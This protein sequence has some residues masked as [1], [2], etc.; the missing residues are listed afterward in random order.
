MTGNGPEPP[1][2]PGHPAH[3]SGLEW[4]WVLAAQETKLSEALLAVEMEDRDRGSIR[5]LPVFQTRDQALILR[6]RLCPNQP[7]RYGA[8]AMLLS[9][10]GLF[11]AEHELEI[12]L[13]DEDGTILARLN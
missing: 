8:Q 6:P 9:E 10:A 11:A 12:L 7:G 3:L 5:T 4:V 2:P 1:S 13:L